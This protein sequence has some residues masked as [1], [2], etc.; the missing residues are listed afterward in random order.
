VFTTVFEQF[1][2]DRLV[3]APRSMVWIQSIQIHCFLMYVSNDSLMVIMM[4]ET[5]KP[6]DV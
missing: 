2:H 5:M 1:L 6:S 3:F 4:P